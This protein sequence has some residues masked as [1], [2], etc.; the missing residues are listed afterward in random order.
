MY[1][2]QKQEIVEK[3]G[4]LL[5]VG[6]IV[7]DCRYEVHTIIE[8]KNIDDIVMDDG[9][10]CSLIHCCHPVSMRTNVERVLLKRNADAYW[11]KVTADFSDHG[12]FEK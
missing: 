4:R 1:K 5:E 10:C 2:L 8:M 12:E 7:E 3:F 9:C 11:K 6:D